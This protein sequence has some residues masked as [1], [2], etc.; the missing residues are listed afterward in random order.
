VIFSIP[1]LGM[2]LL[3]PRA[4]NAIIGSRDAYLLRSLLEICALMRADADVEQMDISENSMGA[5]RAWQEADMAP[6]S[7]QEKGT[8]ESVVGVVGLLHVNGMLRRYLAGDRLNS[9]QPPKAVWISESGETFVPPPGHA[10]VKSGGQDFDVEPVWTGRA[11]RRA[12]GCGAPRRRA[13]EAGET[14]LS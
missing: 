9:S 8:A 12:P 14:K 5:S 1:L 6:N 10:W 7:V 4:Y 2:L 11:H 3:L 13:Q